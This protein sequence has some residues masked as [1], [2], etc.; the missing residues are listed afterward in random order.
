MG[1]NALHVGFYAPTE[2]LKVSVEEVVRVHIPFLAPDLAGGSLEVW[3][4]GAPLF[5]CPRFLS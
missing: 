2:E 3:M 5:I 1:W 4:V